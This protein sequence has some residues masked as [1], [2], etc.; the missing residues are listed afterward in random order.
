MR[1]WA[2]P[3][4][5]QGLQRQNMSVTL[6]FAIDIFLFRHRALKHLVEN[7]QEANLTSEDNHSWVFSPHFVSGELQDWRQAGSP[8]GEK[9][10]RRWYSW[11]ALR[12]A[13]A[14]LDALAVPAQPSLGLKTLALPLPRDMPVNIHT[15]ATTVRPHVSC[16]RLSG[17]TW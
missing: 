8:T 5:V 14:C 3:Q 4:E 1:L 12:G 16:P 6:Q 15:M 7:T 13:G 10:F 9:C 17:G 11:P 2:R